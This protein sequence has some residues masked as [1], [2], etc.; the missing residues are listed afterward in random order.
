MS[1]CMYLV[2]LCRL[3]VSSIAVSA[4][5]SAVAQ[6]GFDFRRPFCMKAQLI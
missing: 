2:P 5:M 6:A 4:A 3:T 1:H